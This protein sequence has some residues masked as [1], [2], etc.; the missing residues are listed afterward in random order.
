MRVFRQKY[1]GRDGKTKESSKWYVEFKDADDHERRLPGFTDK[2]ATIELGKKVERLVGFR[3]MR[4]ELSPELARWL[5]TLPTDLWNRLANFGLLDAKSVAGK[6]PLAQHIDDFVATLRAAGL[7]K[8]YID[9]VEARVHRLLTLSGFQSISDINGVKVQ[10]SLAKLKA[11][12]SCGIMKRDGSEKISRGLGQQTLNHYL[13]ATKQFTRWLVKEGRTHNNALLHLKGGNANLDIRRERRELLE[14]ELTKLLN[15][16]ENGR[17]LFGLTGEQRRKLYVVAVS[18][19][20]RSKECGSLT[21]RH[22]ELDADP[23]TVRIDAPDEKARRGDVLPIPSDL[24]KMLRPWLA[25][26]APDA[27][28]WPGDWAKKRRGSK[29]M[30]ADLERAGVAYR[31]DDGH[32]SDFYA[33]RHTYLSRLGRSGASPKAMQR[34]VRHTTVQLTLAV[35]RTPICLI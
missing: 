6:K 20:L 15:A 4:D 29:I 25:T 30:M 3:V 17:T 2:S 24:V 28:L 11:N 5:E 12:G 34:L 8:D 26:F 32:Q 18:T 27:K 10:N 16:A 21:P 9:P 7:S 13:T 19:G 14:D 23:P 35:R 22:F 1:K 31:N 33:L